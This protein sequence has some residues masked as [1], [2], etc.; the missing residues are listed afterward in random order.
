MPQTQKSMEIKQLITDALKLPTN[1][2]AY[3]VSKSLTQLYPNREMVEG[4]ECAF[5]LEAYAH[6]GQCSITLKQVFH[7]HVP[8]YWD[9][10]HQ[11]TYQQAENARFEVSWQGHTLDVL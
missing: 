4:S 1:A 5:D 11:R 2:I 9:G 8:S 6:N 10:K 3:H 7:N